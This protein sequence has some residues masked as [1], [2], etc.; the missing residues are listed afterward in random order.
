M[1]QIA[2]NHITYAKS[3]NES[4][5]CESY[6]LCQILQRVRSLWIIL[7]MPN[8]AMCQITVSHSAHTKSWNESDHFQYCPYQILKWVRSFSVLPVPNPA[9]SQII[10]CHIVNTGR[11]GWGWWGG[12][13]WRLLSQWRVELE[14][15]FGSHGFKKMVMVS[16][17]ARVKVRI[18]LTNDTV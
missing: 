15:Q 1:S 3:C 6:Y 5:R 4:D 12:G 17:M 14:L 13:G 8:H 10:V 18:R 2:V 7:P 11:G 16:A 9:M